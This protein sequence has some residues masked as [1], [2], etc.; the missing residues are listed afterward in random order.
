MDTSPFSASPIKKQKLEN[1]QTMSEKKLETCPHGEKC[2]RRNPHH[3]KEYDHPHCKFL[4]SN[5]KTK[6]QGTYH[7]QELIDNI[8]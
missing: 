2:Y 5:S 8:V 1:S 4:L 6:V 3:F 7:L